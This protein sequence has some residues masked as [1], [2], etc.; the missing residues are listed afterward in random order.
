MGFGSNEEWLRRVCGSR[1]RRS[2]SFILP[3]VSDG[4]DGG[5]LSPG[6]GE[7]HW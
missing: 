2:A 1:R 3:L 5:R 6:P 4:N 7:A